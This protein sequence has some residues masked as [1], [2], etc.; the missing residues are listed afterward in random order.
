MILQFLMDKVK[1]VIRLHCF[2]IANNEGNIFFLDVDRF[3][4]SIFSLI[5]DLSKSN[6][7]VNY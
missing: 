7:V 1:N 5:L 4:Y 3:I 6:E 2:I